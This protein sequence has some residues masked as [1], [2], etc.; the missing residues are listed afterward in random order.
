MSE[1]TQANREVRVTTPLGED[2]L[3]IRSMSG[4]EELGKLFEY[5]IDLISET[6]DA[7]FNQLVGDTITVSLEM[8]EDTTRYFNGY[9]SRFAQTGISGQNAIYQATVVPWFWLLTRTSDCRIFQNMTV[10][11]II[12]EVFRDDGFTD[13][14]DAL[15]GSYRTWINCVQYRESDFNFV[16]RLMEQEG[17]YYFFKHEEDKHTLVMADAYSSHEK[18]AGYEEVV[19]HPRVNPLSLAKSIFMTGRWSSSYNQAP[20]YIKILILLRQK[21]IS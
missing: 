19:Y 6:T 8:G 15:S 12:K 18:V 2:V 21:K 7:D 11:D 16:S 9:V 13:F 17:I 1:L 4:R 3:L 20:L 5:H 14:E 10:P